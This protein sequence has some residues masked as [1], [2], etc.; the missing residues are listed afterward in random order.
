MIFRQNPKIIFISRSYPPIIG[1]IETLNY[2]LAESLAKLTPTKIIANRHGK[3]FL[4]FFLPYA[5]FISL[6]LLRRQYNAVILGDG[7]LGIVGW[8]L[9][10]F[11]KKPVFCV[12]CGLD[13]TYNSDLYQNVWVKI[14][15]KNLDKLVAIS[16]ATMAAGIFRGIPR[17]KFTI[18]PVGIDPNKYYRPDYA[19]RNLE[20]AIGKL[21][22]DCKVLLTVGRLV[23]RK[24]V[25][26][27]VEKILPN[28]REEVVYLIA[29]E[30]PEEKRIR[31]IIKAKK[32]E[33]KTR[34][35]GK[36]TEKDKEVLLNTC[37]IFIQP[38]IDI[39]G[40]LEGFGIAVIEAASCG[41]IVVASDIEGLQ[42]AIYD[43][44]NGFLVKSHDA[45]GYTRKIT[46][47]LSDDNFR[48]Q[49]GEQARQFVI[50]NYDWE[51]IAEKYLTELKN[52]IAKNNFYEK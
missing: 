9:K 36:I 27:F 50:E 15:I 52:F 51:S 21:P 49:F 37:D 18:I 29:G 43:G 8:F 19:R 24:G 34:L 31:Q 39:K 32:L 47:L 2:E 38:N 41:R 13:L 25:A 10:L 48:K 40:D 12:V 7:V 28:I 16:R 44:K 42:D 22:P 46:Q 20:N 6:I 30:G 14:F 5:L 33:S 11:S 17:E 23:K 35:L 4:P 26:W 3:F 45:D 1:G